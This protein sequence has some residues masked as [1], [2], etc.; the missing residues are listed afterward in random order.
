MLFKAGLYCTPELRAYKSCDLRTNFI[1]DQFTI[2]N[3]KNLMINFATHW[4]ILATS[5]V[6]VHGPIYAIW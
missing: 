2:L 5:A 1:R 6:R 4:N 3:V